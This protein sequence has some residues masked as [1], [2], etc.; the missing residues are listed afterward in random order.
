M[1]KYIKFFCLFVSLLFALNNLSAQSKKELENRKKRIQNEINET[2]KLIEETR[3]NQKLTINQL[4]LLNKK[5]SERMKLISTMQ[6]E[7][8]LLNGSIQSNNHEVNQ[9]QQKLSS[10]KTSY[11]GMVRQAYMNKGQLTTLIM[12]FSAQ[13]VQQAVKRVYYLRS[14]SVFR[15]KQARLIRQTQTD[16]LAKQTLL[17]TNLQSK[18]SILG[19]EQQ[20]KQVL[21]VE[22]KEQEKTVT[23]LKKKEKELKKALQ[24]KQATKNKLDK[25]IARVIEAEI[26]KEREKAI[27]RSSTAKSK[28][29]AAKSAP[30]M[31]PEAKALS[32]KFEANRGK[33]PWP[34]E[35]GVITEGFGA[36]KHPVLANI[37]TYNN[38]VNISTTK[39]APV[40][41]IFEGEV[42]G[43]IQIPG[44]NTAVIIK[45]G[46]FLTVYGN[47]SSASVNKGDKV[48]IRQTIGTADT[49]GE[50]EPMTHLE[51]WQGKTKLD[52]QLWLAR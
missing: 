47:L 9:L 14:Y 28:T 16:L 18:Q 48:M 44:A 12:F 30:T 45:H 43:V 40:K 36:H 25:E 52:P 10:L 13:D 2:N 7:I 8:S 26:K 6:K 15:R 23:V 38:G 41:T 24:K 34:V 19:S 27:S 49:D 29:I 37:T 11:A 46:E 50:G 1:N 42:A 21:A 39:S 4:N 35:K 32:G 22:K 31:T 51:I 17:R 3:K 33:L 5:I 20:E